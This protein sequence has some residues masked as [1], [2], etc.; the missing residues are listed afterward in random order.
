M[1]KTFTYD[2]FASLLFFV[3]LQNTSIDQ[4]GTSLLVKKQVLAHSMVGSGLVFNSC[5]LC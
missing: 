4:P 3:D 1:L 5:T 2:E